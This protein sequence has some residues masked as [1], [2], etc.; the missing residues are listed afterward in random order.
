MIAAAIAANS[1]RGMALVIPPP[2]GL[3]YAMRHV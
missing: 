3:F 1:A 2:L